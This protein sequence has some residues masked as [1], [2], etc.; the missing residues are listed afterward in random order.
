MSVHPLSME[1][2]KL[3]PEDPQE[4]SLR[5]ETVVKWLTFCAYFHHFAV[6]VS[7]LSN[8]SNAH[9]GMILFLFSLLDIRSLLNV[10][11]EADAEQGILHE[12][13]TPA[14]YRKGQ[15]QP[16]NV[17]TLSWGRTSTGQK[18]KIKSQRSLW[19]GFPTNAEDLGGEWQCFKLPQRP[20]TR[21]RGSS[22][23]CTF[24]FFPSLISIN[25]GPW[26]FVQYI[27]FK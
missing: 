14:R 13:I 18:G 10:F 19:P 6:D 23:F 8:E 26:W 2:S 7:W 11:S 3:R 22:V 5:V 27:F 15:E 12:K 24:P 21:E 25:R 20:N 1:L 9:E 16:R 4:R 17:I